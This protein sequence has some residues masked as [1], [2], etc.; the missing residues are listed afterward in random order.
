[1]FADTNAIR[2]LGSAH[3]VQAADLAAVA[4]ILSSLPS[5]ASMLGPV[6]ARFLAALADAAAGEAR[7]VAALGDSVS[8]A[9]RTAHASATGYDDAD[10]RVGGRIAGI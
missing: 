3:S 7:A 5:G 9:G 4:S 6:A 2:T 10:Q 8:A 1:M